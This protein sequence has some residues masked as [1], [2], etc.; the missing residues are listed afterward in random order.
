MPPPVGAIVAMP[1]PSYPRVWIF[2]SPSRRKFLQGGRSSSVAENE[3]NV[4]LLLSTARE[5]YYENL[6]LKS[7]CFMCTSLRP[8]RASIK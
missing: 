2:S 5:K 8:E 1:A 7:P 3:A 4:S 6:R